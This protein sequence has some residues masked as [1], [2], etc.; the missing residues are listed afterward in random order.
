MALE[1]SANLLRMVSG[2]VYRPPVP[3]IPSH[4]LLATNARRIAAAKV[5]SFIAL[6][7]SAGITT[8]RLQAIFTGDFDPDLDL[9]N[10]LANGLGVSLSEL[11]AESQSN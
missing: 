9:L 8:E 11:F 5:I 1:S 4:E 10:K 2:L 6:A 7:G 3:R